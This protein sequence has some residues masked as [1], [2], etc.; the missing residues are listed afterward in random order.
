[1]LSKEDNDLLCR[2]GPDT[3]MGNLLRQYWMPIL[4]SWEL[5]AEAQPR[6]M[7][8][9]GEELVAFRDSDGRV[10]LLADN[11]SHRGASLFFARNE[12]SGLRCVYHGWK[13]DVAG[14]C[15][16]MPNEPPANNFAHAIRHPA[17]PCQER[18]GL[19]WTYMGPRSEPPPLPDLEFNML[20]DDH[21]AIHKNLQECNWVQALEGNIDSIHLSYLHTRLE[22]DGDAG[23][24]GAQG[25]A[26]GLYYNSK[27]ATMDVSQTDGGVMYGVGREEQPG[28]IYWRVTQ[29]L[30]P[31]WGMF[32]PVSPAECPMQ[33]WIP[34]DDAN[35]MKWDVRWNPNR[36]MTTEERA[37]FTAGDPGGYLPETSDPMTHWRLKGDRTNDY[38]M[39]YED[40]QKK[41]FS[42]VP[43]VNL[44]DKAVQ[45]SMGPII[46]RTREHLGSSDAM[47]AAVRRRLIEAAKALRDEGT[48]PSGVDE[49]EV[50][51][52]RTAT[53]VLPEGESWREATEPYLKAF[54]D[55]PVLSAEAQIAAGRAV[56]TLARS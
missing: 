43:S 51:R 55:L 42:G 38:L 40:Q 53:A 5:E 50:Y 26:R 44:Q 21:V 49:P 34:L 19:I 18:G 9:L 11:C 25:G 46:N 30:M 20:P 29:F 17:Y 35:V 52:V 32:A 28:I 45:E 12:E 4:F 36:P 6:R 48:V 54:T 23:F 31:I 47:I 56:P 1:M 7:R 39:D 8:L 27:Y 16:D 33:W 22:R 3:P 10:G 41:R 15:M 24:P 2:V 14:R 13:Y 37:R